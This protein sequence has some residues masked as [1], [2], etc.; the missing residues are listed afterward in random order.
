MESRLQRDRGGSRVKDQEA[1]G[2]EKDDGDMEQVAGVEAER[3]VFQVYLRTEQ[4]EE[5]NEPDTG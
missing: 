4:R 1:T 3:I 5:T 2:H